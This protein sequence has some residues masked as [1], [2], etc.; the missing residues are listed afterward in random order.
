MG[1]KSN[2]R[3]CFLWF[4]DKAPQVYDNWRDGLRSAIE[5]IG[6]KHKVNWVIGKEY[7]EDVYDVILFW[8]DSNSAFFDK[9]DDYHCKKGLFL[10][11]DPQNFDNLR[12]LDVVYCE[13][14]PVYDAVR[15]QGIHAVK[16]FGTDTDFFR[17]SN[18]KCTCH[19]GYLSTNQPSGDH[20]G[21]CYKNCNG[22]KD[23]EYFYPATFSPWKRQS[24]L[25]PLGDKLLCVGTVQ[26]D[27]ISELQKCLRTGVKVEEGYFPAEKILGYYQRSKKVLIP[28]IHGSERTV[29]ESMACEIKPEVNKENVR[30]YSYIKELE[31]S[32]LEPREFVVKNYSHKKYA[33]DILRGLE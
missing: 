19:E 14:Q 8:D 18:C 30:A 2:L 13:S 9:I 25:A 29:L 17:P 3:I 23:I 12:K 33:E 27:G 16:A 32:G 6:K 11:T 26:P 22:K 20:L 24:E 4:F 28:A 7:P 21:E 10:T 31:E 5:L 15:A 1:N